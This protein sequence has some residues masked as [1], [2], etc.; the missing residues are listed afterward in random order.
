MKHMNWSRLAMLTNLYE[1]K[2][3]LEYQFFALSKFTRC[4]FANCYG[5]VK[6]GLMTRIRVSIRQKDILTERTC[7]GFVSVILGC[8]KPSSIARLLA[9]IIYTR[10]GLEFDLC[11]PLFT[12]SRSSGLHLLICLWNPKALWHWGAP[13]RPKLE[14]QSKTCKE[15]FLCIYVWALSSVSF[16]KIAEIP[17]MR[18]LR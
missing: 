7:S 14:T 16:K 4:E 17:L 9:Y 10:R 15:I 5:K 13:T 12:L 8:C 1:N 6:K 3:L 11:S 2:W 18:C